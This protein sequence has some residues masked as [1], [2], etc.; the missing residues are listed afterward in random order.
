[1]AF[2]MPP[3]THF[4]V[5]ALAL[6]TMTVRWSILFLC[7]ELY[8]A[9]PAFS[10]SPQPQW[11]AQK[12]PDNQVWTWTELR[13]LVKAK[14]PVPNRKNSTR[15]KHTDMLR[16]QKLFQSCWL[17][18]KRCYNYFWSDMPNSFYAKPPLFVWK[19]TVPLLR[20]L[21]YLAFSNR[22][23]R[24]RHNWCGGQAWHG[25]ATPLCPLALLRR[26]PVLSVSILVSSYLLL[27]KCFW[28]PFDNNFLFKKHYS[29]T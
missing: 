13:S 15:E 2:A 10:S 20:H 21:S 28:K 1:M 9:R 23:L 18:G 14:R 5:R 19:Q 8:E 6:C 4:A 25:P 22:N 17:T 24:F 11:V 12:M 26:S 3:S 7:Y 27:F 16:L 29:S